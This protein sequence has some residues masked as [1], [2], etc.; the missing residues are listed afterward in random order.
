MTSC[1]SAYGTGAAFAMRQ[2]IDEQ[3][4]VRELARR[5]GSRSA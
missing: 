5:A 2:R 3:V 1:F 4:G